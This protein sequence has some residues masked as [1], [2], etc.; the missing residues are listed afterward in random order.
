M[1]GYMN[2]RIDT[3]N[4]A[5]VELQDLANATIYRYMPTFNRMKAHYVIS[6][7]EPEKKKGLQVQKLARDGRTWND[8]K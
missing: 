1:E 7:V 5:V 4:E 8:V 3:F 2:K 6:E